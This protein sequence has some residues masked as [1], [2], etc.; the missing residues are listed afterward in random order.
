MTWRQMIAHM[1][2]VEARLEVLRDRP[3]LPRAVRGEIEV[4]LAQHVRP[5][6]AADGRAGRSGE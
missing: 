1:R 3:R 4:V 2:R 5:V 6:L